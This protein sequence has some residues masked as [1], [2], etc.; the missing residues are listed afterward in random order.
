MEKVAARTRAEIAAKVRDEAWSRQSVQAVA[1]IHRLYAAQVSPTPTEYGYWHVHVRRGF[2]LPYFTEP[3]VRDLSLRSDED[4]FCAVYY[5]LRD[6]QGAGGASSGMPRALFCGKYSDER[7]D[8][9]DRTFRLLTDEVLEPSR[10]KWN[11]ERGRLCGRILGW[12]IGAAVVAF[13]VACLLL[14]P[15]PPPAMSWLLDL[16]P[17]QFWGLG[18]AGVLFSFGMAGALVSEVLAGLLGG[19]GGAAERWRMRKMDPLAGEFLYNAEVADA[20]TREFGVL[21]QEDQKLREYERIRAGGA[22]LSREAFLKVHVLLPQ[23][24]QL[25]ALERRRRDDVAALQRKLGADFETPVMKLVEA[26]IGET[27]TP[28]PAAE[29]SA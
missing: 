22:E 6:R 12:L 26:Y 9:I 24:R 17:L 3:V 1:A 23:L 19:A 2:R 4:A 29:F 10:W 13:A 27:A 18:A 16:P 28:R 8:A 14:M 11:A 15:A 25:A 21:N 20:V 7:F 5:S